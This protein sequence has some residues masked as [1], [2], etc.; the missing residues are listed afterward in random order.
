MSKPSLTKQQLAELSALEALADE[1]IDTSDIPEI[2]DDRWLLAKK[3][4]LYRPLK[5]SVTIRLDADVLAWFKEHSGG[6]GYQTEIN[7]ALRRYVAK[8]EKRSG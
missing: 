6:R 3:G 2:T 7:A 5:Q 1:D 4:D 8:R